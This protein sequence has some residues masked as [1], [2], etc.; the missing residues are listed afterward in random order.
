MSGFREMLVG[1][2]KKLVEVASVDEPVSIVPSPV[3]EIV[4]PDAT[5]WWERRGSCSGIGGRCDG[6]L[7]GRGAISH[8]VRWILTE[9]GFDYTMAN[10][11]RH[12]EDKGSFED[13]LG[14]LHR[15]LLEHGLGDFEGIRERLS[16]RVASG[17]E[18]GEVID[19]E[20][21]LDGMSLREF[22]EVACGLD[23]FAVEL[24]L[25]DLLDGADV[26]DDGG[27]SGLG[28]IVNGAP[29]VV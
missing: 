20:S 14:L 12:I 24:L 22:F 5:C 23:Y 1:V 15:Q 13:Y 16:A 21:W 28:V 11:V 19:D 25:N 27:I 7:E 6:V 29:F 9:L 17:E 8:E 18:L 2:W 26:E 4:N 3:G 10:V